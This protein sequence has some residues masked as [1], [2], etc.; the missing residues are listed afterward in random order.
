MNLHAIASPF[1]SAV[2]PLI[3]ILVQRSTGYNTNDDGTQVPSYTDPISVIAQVQALSAGDLRQIE[4][5]NIQGEK[6]AV[7]INGRTDGIIR[8]DKKGGDLI[9]M[10]PGKNTWFIGII[11]DAQLIVDQ[12]LYGS[13]F[14]GQAIFGEDVAAGTIVT[15]FGTGIGGPGSYTISPAQVRAGPIFQS[16]AVITWLN[17]HV[18]EYWPDWCKFIITR[19]DGQ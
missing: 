7:Y 16:A 12:V 10:N 1:V 18:L 8:Q 14:V 17:T 11:T 5:L 15:A 3:P 19:Q 6:R 2:N 4:G 9:T 13:I